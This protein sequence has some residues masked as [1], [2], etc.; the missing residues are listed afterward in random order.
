MPWRSFAARPGSMRVAATCV[1]MACLFTACDRLKLLFSHKPPPPPPVNVQVFKARTM[2]VPMYKQWVG[3]T[4]GYQNA[5]IRARV[6][7]YLI[8]QNYI[9]G[10]FVKAGAVLFQ[11]DPRPFQATLMQAKAQY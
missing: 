5:D 3:T 8:Q 9:E 1:M 7:G 6:N 2:D 10:S 4:T 11:I